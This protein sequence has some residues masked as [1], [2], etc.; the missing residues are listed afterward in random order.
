MRLYKVICAITLAVFLTG[1]EKVIH[2]DLDTAAPRLVVDASINWIRNTAG[3]E[4]KILLSTTT[5]YY[6]EDFPT[7]SGATVFITNSSGTDSVLQ[8]PT[9][10]ANT[11]VQIFNR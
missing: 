1:C 2:V 7:V 3:N 6:N 8:K 4:Q 9:I 5:G 10:R 11:A